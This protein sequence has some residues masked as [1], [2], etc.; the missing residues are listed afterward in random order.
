MPSDAITTVSIDCCAPELVEPPVLIIPFVPLELPP[1][2]CQLAIVKSPKS[3]ALPS[4]AN[5][6]LSILLDA[7]EPYPPELKAIVE[8]LQL[9][10]LFSTPSAESP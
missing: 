5:N 4:V 1:L 9:P 8:L 6:F 10:V 3:V 7:L 2:H